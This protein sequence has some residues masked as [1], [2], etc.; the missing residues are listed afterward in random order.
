ME[1]ESN[2]LSNKNTCNNGSIEIQNV[3]TINLV[4]QAIPRT[5]YRYQIVHHTAVLNI[6]VIFV[7]ATKRDIVYVAKVEV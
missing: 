6:A 3:D 4:H 1:R 7:V 2:I 5:P